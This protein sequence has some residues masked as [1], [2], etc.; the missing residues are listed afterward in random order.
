VS[1]ASA[2]NGGVSDGGSAT[3]PSAAVGCSAAADRGPGPVKEA[4]V[5]V[6]GSGEDESASTADEKCTISD[7]GWFRGFQR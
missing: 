4:G 7:A 3:A 2:A 1:D 6:G 5:F